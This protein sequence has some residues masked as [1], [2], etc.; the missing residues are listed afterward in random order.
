MVH[1]SH[2]RKHGNKTFSTIATTG[3]VAAAMRGEPEGPKEQTTL[4]NYQLQQQYQNIRNDITNSFESNMSVINTRS[5]AAALDY[6]G[7]KDEV[8]NSKHNIEVLTQRLASESDKLNQ[9]LK[10]INEE[11]SGPKIIK[12][13]SEKEGHLRKMEEVNEKVKNKKKLR[14]EQTKAVYN[15]Y[16]GNYHD[17]VY[18][19]AP[20][21]ISSSSW[22]SWSP[23]APYMN[24]NPASRA[25]L[26]F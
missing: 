2:G 20:W 7:A 26:R 22:Y 21:E 10:R 12:A 3:S 11:N 19:Y 15:K 5:V 18:G 24:L 1:R 23:L 9:Y 14:G 6:N 17:P 16:E 8:N 25:G 13:V 4:W